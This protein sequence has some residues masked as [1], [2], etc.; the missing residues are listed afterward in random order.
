MTTRPKRSAG[1]GTSVPTFLTVAQVAQRL[2]VC[3]ETILRRLRAGLFPGA[4]FL[5]STW[6]IPEADVMSWLAE[7]RVRS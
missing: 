4:I 2:R 3:R 1:R 7:L 6:R 5:G